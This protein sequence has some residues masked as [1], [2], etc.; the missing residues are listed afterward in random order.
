MSDV[1]RPVHFSSLKAMAQS[2]KHYL[3][4]A[5]SGR[6]DTVSMRIGRVVHS[7]A[8]GG[9]PIAAYTGIRRGKKWLAFQEEHEG[10]ELVSVKEMEVARRAAESLMNHGD[11]MALI[12]GSSMREHEFSWSRSGVNCEGRVDFVSPGKYLG[13][14]K[15]TRS[16]QPDRFARQAI[17]MGY[18][19]QLSWYK[20]GLESVGIKVPEAYLISVENSAPYPVVVRRMTPLAM[21][22]GHKLCCLWLE[23]L[24][25]CAASGEWPGYASTTI[26]LDVEAEVELDFGSE[27]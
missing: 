26:D 2:A 27:E 5:S 11:A 23:Q 14:L 10:K 21:E 18:H 17:G 22:Y 4:A 16:A 12:E 13:D 15:L 24:K 1:D 7:L 9:P 19:A 3:H 20:F 8:L 25:V 6:P